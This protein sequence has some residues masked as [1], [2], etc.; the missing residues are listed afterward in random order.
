MS[1]NRV[2][3]LYAGEA[4]ERYFAHRNRQNR[5]SAQW[6]SA[7]QFKKHIDPHATVLDFGC[8]TGG[9]LSQIPCRRRIGI[10]VNESSIIAAQAAG[11][12]VHPSILD[13]PNAS[14]DVVMSHHALEHIAQPFQIVSEFLRVLKPGGKLIIVVPCEPG[15]RRRFRTWHEQ[16][17]M[18]LYSWNPLSLGN[19]VVACGFSNIEAWAATGGYSRFN[20]WLLPVPPLF[21]VAAKLFGHMLGRFNTVCVA[22]K[23]S[24]VL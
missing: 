17:D 22:S 3:A 10:E 8:G 15:R 24:E 14:I 12:E 4:G 16:L 19:L 23:P 20:K 9:I 7:L 1:A 6:Y 13:V 11:I 21:E 2:E 5:L 18:H